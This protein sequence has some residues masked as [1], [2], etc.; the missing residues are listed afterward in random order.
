MDTEFPGD[1]FDGQ[2]QYLMVRENVNKLKLI[3]LGITLSNSEGEFPKPVC[4]W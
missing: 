3:Q 1:V 2:T 4:T